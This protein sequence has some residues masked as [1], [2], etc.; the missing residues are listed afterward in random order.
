MAFSQSVAPGGRV[1]E[2][3]AWHPLGAVVLAA[4][5]GGVVAM[6]DAALQPLLVM[7]EAPGRTISSVAPS[8][9]VDLA[10]PLRLGGA[11]AGHRRGVAPLLDWARPVTELSADG[12][13]GPLYEL[14]GMAIPCL[15]AQEFAVGVAQ[16]AVGGVS[17]GRLRVQ[18]LTAQHLSDGEPLRALNLVRPRP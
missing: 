10:A 11:V 18:E 6:L 8:Y 17:G 1:V 9:E 2:A 14:V 7:A 13:R 16:V 4:L 12:H 5:E 3:L 15:G